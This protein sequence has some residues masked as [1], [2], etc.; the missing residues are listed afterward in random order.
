VEKE[1]ERILWGSR[2]LKYEEGIILKFEKIG[3]TLVKGGYVKIQKTTVKTKVNIDLC[4]NFTF[5]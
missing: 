1:R 5:F 4:S 3:E 2:P